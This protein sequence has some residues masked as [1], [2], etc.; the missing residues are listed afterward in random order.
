MDIITLSFNASLTQEILF[1][2]NFCFLYDITAMICLKIKKIKECS[3]SYYWS[4]E[5]HLMN[6]KFIRVRETSLLHEKAPII[7]KF[8]E[9]RNICYS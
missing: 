5:E 1:M 6:S 8:N 7:I 9:L 3:R 4:L 2:L